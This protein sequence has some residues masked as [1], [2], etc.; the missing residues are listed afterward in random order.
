ME[1]D[2]LR[3]PMIY[4]CYGV[5]KSASTYLYQLTEEILRVAGRRTARVGPP[6]RPATSVD[7][8]LDDI[9]GDTLDGIARQWPGCDFVLKTHGVLEPAVA[10]RIEAGT[11]LASAAI[12][13]PREIALSMIDHGR[14][15]RRWR[16]AEFS[17]FVTSADSFASL[18]EQVRRFRQWAGVAPI[19]TYNAICYDTERVVA[20]VA[21]QMGV[22]VEAA[23]VLDPFRSKT[24]VG[25]FN[26]G[27][28]LRY[29]EM[30][31]DDQAAFLDRYAALY[32]DIAFDTPQAIA[33][34]T[35][36]STSVLKPRGQAAQFLT[37]FR[38]YLRG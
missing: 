6:F 14:R 1:P 31:P 7:N 8:Y 35:R 30:D 24:G 15:S 29:R 37:Q 25:Q 33:A 38:R 3:R 4:I 27:A 36:Q 10:A 13:D 22:S 19:F 9:T 12:R 21:A 17:E 28:A 26:K 20:A 18:D 11:V 34:A 32:A 5:T 16:Y 23:R 2:G